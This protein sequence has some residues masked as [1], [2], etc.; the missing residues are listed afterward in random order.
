M[1]LRLAHTLR[2]AATPGLSL[3]RGEL[4]VATGQDVIGDQ[5]FAA[6]TMTLAAAGVLRY[7]RRIVLPTTTLQ[8]ADLGAGSM[9]S[10]RVSAS[11]MA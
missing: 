4:P 3:D 11:F 1:V 10:A 2:R 9:C 6:A 8:A 5:G 7:S